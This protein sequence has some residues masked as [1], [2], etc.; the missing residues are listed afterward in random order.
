M[1]TY[2][3]DELKDVLAKHQLCLDN[4]EG[5]VHAYLRN[6]AGTH[7]GGDCLLC[8]NFEEGSGRES[9]GRRRNCAAFGV[10]FCE[11]TPVP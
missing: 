11:P 1:K 3:V 8:G 4:K 10:P 9:N 6:C 5:G 2:T 7:E